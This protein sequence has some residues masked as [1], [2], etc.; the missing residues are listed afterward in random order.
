MRGA[1]ANTE[2][3]LLNKLVKWFTCICDVHVT[4]AR[5]SGD[6]SCHTLMEC[7]QG[8]ASVGA[9]LLER[10]ETKQIELLVEVL[11]D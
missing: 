7:S 1:E 3:H 2:A 5:E 4:P 10:V 8:Q 6:Y 9:G 11:M